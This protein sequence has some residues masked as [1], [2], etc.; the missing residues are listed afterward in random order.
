MCVYVICVY[1]SFVRAPRYYMSRDGIKAVVVII[2]SC[3][4]VMKA[5]VPVKKY[6]KEKNKPIN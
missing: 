5:N 6:T 4:F 1:V 3:L 2:V